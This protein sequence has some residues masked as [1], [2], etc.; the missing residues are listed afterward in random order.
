MSTVYV[1]FLII[2]RNCHTAIV[3]LASPT[4]ATLWLARGQVGT[5]QGFVRPVGF[6]YVG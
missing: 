2:G 5:E 6:F 3:A 4:A 1:V